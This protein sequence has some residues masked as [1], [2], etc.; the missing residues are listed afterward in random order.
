MYNLFDIKLEIVAGFRSHSDSATYSLIKFFTTQFLIELLDC[1]YSCHLSF[2]G[3]CLTIYS[4]KREGK[5]EISQN[6]EA[7]AALRLQLLAQSHQ[8]Y[9]FLLKDI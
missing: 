8:I 1:L 2:Y 4:T 6:Q 7:E 9:F 5:N 3:C